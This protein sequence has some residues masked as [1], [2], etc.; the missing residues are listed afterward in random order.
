MLGRQD[1]GEVLDLALSGDGL[2]LYAATTEGP[3]RLALSFSAP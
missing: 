3:F 1:I 2:T